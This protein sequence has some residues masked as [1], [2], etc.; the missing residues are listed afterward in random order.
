MSQPSTIALIVATKGRAQELYRLFESLAQQDADGFEV[1]V[2]D[3]NQDRRVAPTIAAFRERF[4]IRHLRQAGS[5]ASRA[6]NLGLAAVSADIVGFPDDDS[7]YLPD[8][9]ARVRRFFS[10]HPD[11]QGLIAR[12]LDLEGDGDAY[13][14]AD[15]IATGDVDYWGGYVL[16]INHA[17]FFRAE[18][19]VGLA[20]DEQMGVGAA[21]PWRSAEDPDYLFQALDAGARVHYDPELR[22]RHPRPEDNR[23]LAVLFR[24]ELSY[25]LGNGYLIAK[26]RLPIGLKLMASTAYYQQVVRC[27][28]TGRPRRALVFLGAAIGTSIGYGGGLLHR[29][30]AWASGSRRGPAAPVQPPVDDDRGDAG[31]DDRQA[32]APGDG[33]SA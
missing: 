5:G 13:A 24:R 6:R 3:Q 22:V 23:G 26:H 1:I 30:Q 16:G 9:L 7:V 25:G 32:T 31:A 2:V 27:V 4:P 18:T 29:L 21:T 14:C 20:F 19:A 8:T 33:R 12:V 11:R 15:A 17:M 28:L 10:E